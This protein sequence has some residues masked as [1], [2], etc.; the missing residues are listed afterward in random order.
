MRQR[1]SEVMAWIAI[2][3]V[4]VAASISQA[5]DRLWP[6]APGQVKAG[7]EIGRRIDVTINNN[8][9]VLDVD[10]DFLKPFLERKGVSGGYIG[11]GKLIDSAVLLGAA[12]GDPKVIARKDHLIGKI[13]ASQEPDGYL[14]LFPPEQRVSGLWDVHEVQYIIWGLLEDHRYFKS[15]RSLEAA[16]KAA[17]HLIAHWAKIPADWGTKTGVATHVAVTGLER[18]M[19]GLH[20]TTGDK[21]YLDF[22][23]N[24]RALAKWDLPIV[25]GRRPGIEGHI[26]AYMARCLAQLELYGSPAGSAM[27]G[28]ESLMVPTRR[29]LDFMTRNDGLMVTGGGGQWE[30]WTDD[31]DGRGELGE[32]CATAYQ[33]RVYDAMLRQQGDP[34]WGDL[35]E[36]TIHNTLFAA[37]SP[38]GRR[39]RYFAPTEGPRIYHPTDTYCC[40]CNYRRIVAELPGFIYYRTGD[41]IAVNLLAA[42]QAQ[43]ANVGGTRVR[44]S[45][46]TK[47]PAEG[48]VV[49]TLAP[50]AEARFTL[51]V[52]IPRWAAGA[53]LTME[54]K[55]IAAEP[56]KPGEFARI[57]RLWKPGDKIRLELPM[58]FRLVKGRQRQAGRVAI[59]RGPQ[60]FCLDPAQHKAIEK[61]DGAD[62]GRITLD[63]AT[64]KAVADDTIHPGGIAATVQ[65]WK[66]SFG[67]S[68]KGD[69][70]LKLTEFPNPEGKQTYFRLRDA[71]GAV[72]DE[73]LHTTK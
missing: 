67:L 47:Y 59:V 12:T 54:G 32:T 22:V 27:E 52:R 37:Q 9:L 51:A 36:R 21:K 28:R 49:F 44:I 13:I 19:L 16:K 65:A 72:D 3:C 11:L 8:L 50:E 18:T 31:Q 14:G 55:A 58:E 60:V 71:K 7:G 25:I 69:F 10:K 62:L 43:M 29:A 66:A 20:R 24:E 57:N 61:L 41:G 40:P 63:P 23:M 38:D 2:G 64:L 35:M 45:Q 56:V 4:T 34:Y 17:D 70:E 5:D 33:L 26:Y 53:R 48:E 39:L 6:L 46:E 30:I 68:A 73:L 42:S 1:L 15:A